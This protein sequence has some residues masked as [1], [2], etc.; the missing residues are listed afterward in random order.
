M[1]SRGSVVFTRHARDR[2]DERGATPEDVLHAIATAKTATYQADRDCWRVTG[3]VDI[4][5]DD[6]SIVCVVEAD[7]ILI[8][9]F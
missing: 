1:A 5:E 4:E 9:L 7:V 3:G 8:T 6:L 2:M